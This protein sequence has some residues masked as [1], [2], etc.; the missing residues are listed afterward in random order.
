MAKTDKELTVEIVSAFITSWNSREEAAL[1]QLDDVKDLIK[2][3]H[4]TISQL[5]E[6]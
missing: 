5:P 6:K 3:I 4:D 1:L 2:N